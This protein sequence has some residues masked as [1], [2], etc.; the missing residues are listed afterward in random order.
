M[1]QL[2]GIICGFI[3]LGTWGKISI[4][5]LCILSRVYSMCREY[6]PVIYDGPFTTCL[7][8]TKTC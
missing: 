1:C 2:W 6:M 4:N 7:E 5:I 3:T 8:V